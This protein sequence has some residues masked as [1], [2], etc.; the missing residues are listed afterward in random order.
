[1]NA[2]SACAPEGCPECGS[3]ACVLQVVRKDR[4][5]WRCEDCRHGWCEE[6]NVAP[7]GRASRK[8]SV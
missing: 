7:R 8:R 1:M 6:C 3:L 2:A 4:L 5:G